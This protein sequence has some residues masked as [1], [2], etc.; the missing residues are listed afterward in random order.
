MWTPHLP[1]SSDVRSCRKSPSPLIQHL[2]LLAVVMN[3]PSR[4]LQV[5]PIGKGKPRERALSLSFHGA[6]QQ[7]HGLQQFLLR[8]AAIH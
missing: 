1:G 6:S 4:L 3:P 7:P 2:L 8:K 5:H